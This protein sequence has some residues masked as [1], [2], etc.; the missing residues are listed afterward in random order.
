MALGTDRILIS[1]TYVEAIHSV[2]KNST[3]KRSVYVCYIHFLCNNSFVTCIFDKPTRIYQ[4]KRSLVDDSCNVLISYTNYLFF[5]PKLQPNDKLI[6]VIWCVAA[7]KLEIKVC[8]RYA[9][10]ASCMISIIFIYD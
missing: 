6:L 7:S 2:G 3:N 1:D 4:I 8:F 5:L 10:I 9:C